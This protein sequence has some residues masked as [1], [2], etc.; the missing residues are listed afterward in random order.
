VSEPVRS[1]SVQGGGEKLEG[2]LEGGGEAGAE[3]LRPGPFRFYARGADE[4]EAV[5]KTGVIGAAGHIEGNTPPVGV[6]YNGHGVLDLRI[7]VFMQERSVLGD[8]P[9]LRRGGRAA[10][11][12][13]VKKMGSVFRREGVGERTHVFGT[14]SPSVKEKKSG[15]VVG[16]V[17]LNI[18]V[19]VRHRAGCSTG[20]SATEGF[21]E[22]ISI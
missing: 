6:A 1:G 11:A 4:D 2:R 8:A 15:S 9:G 13:Q 18:Q 22:T 19:V 20:E 3:N 21:R 14:A 17:N 7:D 5:H 16:A 12:R 10:V